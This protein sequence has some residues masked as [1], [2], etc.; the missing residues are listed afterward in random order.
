MDHLK[1]STQKL[2]Y[3]RNV[4]FLARPSP[5]MLHIPLSLSSNLVFAHNLDMPKVRLANIASFGS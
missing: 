4:T 1:I 5:P 2:T 3:Q